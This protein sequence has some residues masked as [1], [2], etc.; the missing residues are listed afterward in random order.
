MRGAGPT[1]VLAFLDSPDPIAY[2]L[3]V[4]CFLSVFLIVF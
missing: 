1:G 3:R 2:H 4:D